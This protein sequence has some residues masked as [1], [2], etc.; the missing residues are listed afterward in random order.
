MIKNLMEYFQ[1]EQEFYLQ[2]ISYNRL[3]KSEQEN[4]SLN[5]LDNIQVEKK[6]NKVR[7]TV[8]R[9]L[10]FD[11]EEF[12]NLNISFGAVL[13]FAEER[14]KEYDWSKINLAEEFKNNGEFVTGNLMSRISLLT[15]QITSSFGQQPIVLPPSVA[16]ESMDEE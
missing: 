10:E 2:N 1:P 13:K 11:P 6:G 9:S 16:Q 7:I 15:A 5:C 4:H 14:E 3:E 8:T 12:F